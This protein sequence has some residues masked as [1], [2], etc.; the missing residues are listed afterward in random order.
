MH[1]VAAL[2]YGLYDFDFNPCIS[3]RML[4][5]IYF[6]VLCMRYFSLTLLCFVQVYNFQ[7][8]LHS[9]SKKDGMKVF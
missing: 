4:L 5:S 2:W 3:G 8:M 1:G 6:S 9:F 7:V